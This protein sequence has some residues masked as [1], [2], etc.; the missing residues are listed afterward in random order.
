VH[1]IRIEDR[2]AV[3]GYASRDKLAR[4]VAKSLGRL[5]VADGQSAYLPL[6]SKLD[7]AAGIFAEVKALLRPVERRP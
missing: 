7:D 3:F 5:R 6:A 2:F 4:L 1:E